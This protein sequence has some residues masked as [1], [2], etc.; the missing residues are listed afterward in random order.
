VK[1]LQWHNKEDMRVDDIPVPTPRPDEVLIKVLFSGICGSEVHEYF[2]GPLYVPLE[3]HPLTGTCAPQTM[4]HEFGGRIEKLGSEVKGLAEGTLVTVNPVLSCGKCK[5]CLRNRP[6]LCEKLA[7]YGLIGD[8]GHAEFAVVKAANCVPLPP[9]VPLEYVAFGEP[10]GVSFHA[11]NQ[12]QIEPGST[13]VILGGGPIGQLVA[14][15]AR[16]AGAKK[17]F[18]T[19]IATDRIN[20]VKNIGAVDEVLNPL[21]VDISEAIM[22]ETGGQGAD[23]TIEC[24]GGNKTGM[25]EDTATQAVELTR[26]E[27]TTVMVGGFAEP[28]DFNFNNIVMME[29]KVVGSWIWHTQEEY[30]KAVQMFIEGKVKVLPLVS[31]KVRIE[32]AVEEGI[33]ALRFH[34]DEHVKILIDLT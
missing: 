12:A 8:G 15:Y 31:R 30:T 13:V 18:M 5:P 23:Y 29:R 2:S 19:E 1:A 32:N 33:L 7:V 22:S 24:C 26:S 9:D 21:E 20:I 11:V 17:I 4:G 14:Q 28:T 3:P 16:L 6:N 34:K 10:A 27:G 25:L